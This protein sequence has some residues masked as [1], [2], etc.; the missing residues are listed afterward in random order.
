MHKLSIQLKHQ[1]WLYLV[2]VWNGSTSGRPH[3]LSRALL[4]LL[5]GAVVQTCPLRMSFPVGPSFI[6]AIIWTCLGTNQR[7]VKKRAIMHRSK[8]KSRFK[9]CHSWGFLFTHWTNSPKCAA[10]FRMRRE[11]I[12]QS[13]PNSSTGS[14]L[15]WSSV[16]R[17]KWS[18]DY[19][20]QELWIF[21]VNVY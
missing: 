17:S 20:C 1:M 9:H 8:L 14:E 13:Y 7:F 10:I 4:V 6:P 11:I 19:L 5:T 16:G 18:L 21:N 2:H 15:T 12:W 3:I